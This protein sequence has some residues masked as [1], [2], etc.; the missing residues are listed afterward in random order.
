MIPAPAPLPS[1]S[2]ESL[3]L[4][5]EIATAT[6]PVVLAEI[7]RLLAHEMNQPLAAIVA[8]GGAALRWLERDPPDIAEAATAIRR[9]MDAA[10][11]A[12]ESMRGIQSLAQREAGIRAPVPV[13]E[14]VELAV[15]M[16]APFARA[17]GCAIAI[18]CQERL[19]KVEADRA[20]ML[21]VLAA[22]LNNACEAVARVPEPRQIRVMARR[23]EG[24]VAISVG[25]NGPGLG[26]LGRDRPFEPFFTIK[27]DGIGL[28]LAVSRAI[29]ESHGG[30]L[31][32]RAN[33]GDG[34]SF[35]IT[36]PALA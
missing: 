19:P 14:L 23:F 17:Q 31:S 8:N 4:R 25:D 10:Q 30:R 33:A 21:Y 36:L 32:A 34:E 22:L 13:T 1:P 26:S 27:A 3:T 5:H 7:A 12:A 15:A 16:V 20:Q 28:G 18:E 2:D 11:R 24:D 6:Q 35:T 9:L 29:V